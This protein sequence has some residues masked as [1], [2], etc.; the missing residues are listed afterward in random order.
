[1]LFRSVSHILA[2]ER[3]GNLITRNH[4]F[5]DTLSKNRSRRMEAD[6]KKMAKTVEPDTSNPKRHQET[7]EIAGAVD[8]LHTVLSVYHKIARK[9][10]VDNVIQ[11]VDYF[12]LS[13]EQSP[14]NILTTGFVSQM[15][16]EQLERCAGEDEVSKRER[17]KF[18]ELIE[19]L[20]EG[21]NVLR[22]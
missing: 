2:V 20:Q 3:S 21:M 19:T 17:A 1:M 15:T 7:V 22:A 18:T 5:H 11:N 4:Y 16:K 13:G 8:E 10:V 6:S 9:R 12:L 14:L